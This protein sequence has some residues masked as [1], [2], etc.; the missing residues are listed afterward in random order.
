MW[1]RQK[2]K[3]QTSKMT[4]VL[5]GSQH[6]ESGEVAGGDLG[7]GTSSGEV[8]SALRSGGIPAK[9]SKTGKGKLAERGKCIPGRGN[10]K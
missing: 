5:R 3:T 2:V 8:R 1:G 7:G 9:T 4:S 10:I 6:S